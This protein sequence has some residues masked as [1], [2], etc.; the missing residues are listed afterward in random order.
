MPTLT[1]DR[2]AVWKYSPQ[3]VAG[4]RVVLTGGT[5]GL[6]RTTAL[7]LA[8]QGAHV[9]LFGRH[10]EILD[11]AMRDLAGV[12]D[13]I[14]PMTADHADEA[15]VDRVFARADDE[16]GGID[17]LIN[18]AADPAG[19]TTDTDPA[20][21]R[22]V[23]E[24]NLLGY[25]ACAKR[26]VERMKKNISG[27]TS[28]NTS[29]GGGDIVNVGSLSA[30]ARGP[31]TDIYVATK[32]AVRG[33]S[34]AL[35]KQ[36]HEHGI[37]VT[38]IEPGSFGADFRDQSDAENRKQQKQGRM[39]FTEPI[40]ELI[41]FALTQPRDVRLPLLQVHPLHQVIGGE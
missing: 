16:L 1:H 14:V 36:L 26:A 30:T 4:K 15:D 27:N 23:I 5:S 22:Y 10:R 2:P 21:Y 37:R 33:W 13:R 40:A 24:N 18:N 11:E 35:G 32:S 29:G 12:A 3:A 19:A 6:G 34:D 31:D 25:M 38:L 39:L 28:G 17:V 41:L 9:L 8:Q 7:L 20:E